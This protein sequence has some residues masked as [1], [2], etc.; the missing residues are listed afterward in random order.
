MKTVIIYTTKSCPKCQA[1]K[2]WLNKNNE[3]FEER[4]LEETDVMT[5]LVMDN[6]SV[7]SAPIIRFDDHYYSF[8]EFEELQKLLE[9]A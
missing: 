1:V 8:S 3:H 5:E 7:F 4:N 6:V 9:V 2:N